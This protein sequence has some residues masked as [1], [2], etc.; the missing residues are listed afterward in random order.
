ML[1]WHGAPYLIDHGADADLPP[2]LV[3]PE[4]PEVVAA[5][6]ARPYDASAHV[7]LA[8]SSTAAPDL[9]AADAALAPLRDARAG[10]GR[11]R[12]SSPTAGWTCPASPTPR[13]SATPTSRACW[14]AAT[15]GTRGCRRCGRRSRTGRPGSARR[16]VAAACA[17]DLEAVAVTRHPFEYAVIRVVP[18]IERGEAINAGVLLYCRGLDYLGARVHLDEAR[19]RALDPGADADGIACVLR[20]LETTCGDDPSE[21]RRA[22]T[23]GGGGPRPPLPAAHR[24]AQHDGAARPGAHGPDGRPGGRARAPVRRAGAPA[25]AADPPTRQTGTAAPRVTGIA[26]KPRSR[27][28]GR[29]CG[30]AA[31]ARSGNRSNSARSPI[32]PSIRASPAPRQ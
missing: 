18:R 8:P 26:S 32:S 31:S 11:G 27:R 2:R 19:L 25:A 17:A 23:G 22:G 16:R 5:G 24:P 12:R 13:R 7:L 29:R 30:G 21:A 9:D 6:A 20:A 28:V 3:G 10:P 15:P 14:P 1:R 4:P